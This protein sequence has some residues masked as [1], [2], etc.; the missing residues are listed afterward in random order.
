MDLPSL[1]AHP[2]LLNNDTL[3]QLQDMVARFPCY[4]AA[5]LLLVQNAYRTEDV[6]FM[7][8]AEK[9]AV[10]LPNRGVLYDLTEGYR[11]KEANRERCDRKAEPA[12]KTGDDLTATVIDRY[13]FGGS[14][15]EKKEKP[16]DPAADYM[17]Y[18]SQLE[19]QSGVPYAPGASSPQKAEERDRTQ[20]LL[21][22]VVE[23][24]NDWFTRP[25]LLQDEKPLPKNSQWETPTVADDVHDV[26]DVYTET[27]ANIC[28]KQGRYE[29]AIEILS[30]LNLNNPKKS[31][32]FADKIRFLR[33][34]A[35]DSKY[36][37]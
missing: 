24:G 1:I 19:A 22:S 6:S 16:V 20:V 12:G 13:L 5:R 10:L 14:K 21:D 17:G 4:Q 30:H 18:L 11:N 8:E 29:R 34:L 23:L 3:A 7:N 2:E 15:P 37:S 35:I 36:K 25:A 9:A 28:M 33:K 26:A 27:L 31:A 32:Y